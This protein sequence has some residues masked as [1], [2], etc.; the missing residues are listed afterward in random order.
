VRAGAASGDNACVELERR[1]AIRLGELAPEAGRVVL[2]VSGGPDSMAALHLL[3]AAGVPVTAAHFDHRLRPDS[4]ADVGFV[5]AACTALNVPVRAGG[6]DVAA[7][8]RDR[9][10]NL[11]DA[12][13]RLRYAFLADTARGE[14]AAVVVVAHT[15]DDQAETVL[16]QLLRGAAFV[17]GMPARRGRVV[18]P[19]LDVPRAA[20]R[21]YLVERGQAFLDD[22]SNRD[23]ER[24]RAWL[25]SE[26]LPLLERR[27]PGTAARLARTASVQ[28]DAETALEEI[29]RLRFGD[30]PLR[31]EALL[32]APAGLQRAALL[33][34]LAAADA[35]VDFERI[36][37]ARRALAR[38][39][40]WRADLGGGRVLRV[41]YGR[42]EVARRSQG[43]EAR[44]VSLPEEL[45][46][47]VSPA[48]L[49][50]Y[51]ELML[52]GR[53]RGDRIR[54]PGGSR[55]LSDVLVDAKVPREARDGVRL[56]A[57]GG[58]V[59]WVEGLAVA[60]GVA[61]SA[62][63]EPDGDVAMM[64]RALALA[65]QAAARGELPVG[66]VL[67]RGERVLGE[68]ANASEEGHDPTA[69]AEIIALRRAAAATNDW[70]LA[71]STLYVTLEPCPM[72]L[73]AVLQA[74]VGRLV[75]GADNLREGAL[76]GVIDLRTGSWKRG[77]EVRGGVLARQA[78]ELLSAFFARRRNA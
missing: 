32:R 38:S 73:G 50:S 25:R 44:R 13:R 24:M 75:Y 68:G 69:H 30:G 78:A 77:I 34:L 53:R 28:R 59:L 45:P 52:R 51:P 23:R 37:R 70:R 1:V 42:V 11:E 18:R 19:L 3:V 57:S 62:A 22:A 56:L 46:E 61:A 16:L 29:A 14:G 6:A 60:E 48:L 41:A 65:R 17:R 7:V 39:R 49:A 58:D 5:R 2:G 21:T 33:R 47:G 15:L 43:V 8:A 27:A 71:G 20:L 76:G 74:H 55:L 67:A 36:E 40:P 66:A 26:V 72:C 64:R 31:R 4:A 10:W 9:G 12:G 54:L 35:G 63:A